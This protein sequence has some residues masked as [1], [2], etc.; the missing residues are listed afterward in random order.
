MIEVNPARKHGDA[1]LARLLLE[2]LPPWLEAEIRANSLSIGEWGGAGPSPELLQTHF[3]Q[4]RTAGV[5]PTH[6]EP[7]A[8]DVIAI[9]DGLPATSAPWPLLRTLGFYAMRHIVVVAPF[10]GDFHTAGSNPALAAGLI[11]TSVD[12]DFQLSS[13]KLIDSRREHSGSPA[14]LRMLLVYSRSR[15]L[16]ASGARFDRE[17]ADGPAI[18]YATWND[19]QLSIL[20]LQMD[21]VLRAIGDG[22][23]AAAY[24]GKMAAAL[25]TAQAKNSELEKR[26][27]QLR[28]TERQLL[29]EKDRLQSQIAALQQQHTAENQSLTARA[30]ANSYEIAT[31]RRLVAELRGSLSWKI[32]APLRALTKPLFLLLGGTSNPPAATHSPA[33]SVVQDDG[34]SQPAPA[35]RPQDLLEP[36]L[37]VLRSARSIA[38]IPC[39]IP[40]SSTLNQR[41]ISCAR[42]LADRGYTVLYVAWQWS[43]GEEI[44]RAGEE[45]Y[46]GVFHLPLYP[47]LNNLDAIASASH[48]QSFYLCTL[49]SPALVEAAGPLRA[50]GYHIHYDIMD[51][52]EGFHRGGEAPWFS[53]PVEREMV[54]LADTVTVVS[55]K[56]AEKFQSLRSDIE[57]VRNGYTPSALSCEVFL[58]ARTPLE[59]PKTI[60][61]FGHLS[62]A[63]FDW[64]ALIHAAKTLPSVDFEII[65]WGVSDA[66]RLH[67]SE[68]ENIR[69]A[70]L[71]PQN[72]LHRYAKRWW[73][74]I[75]PF[76]ST[77]VSAAV[78]PLKIYEYLHLGL[79]S[80]VTGIGG[81]ASFPLVRFAKDAAGFAA[82]IAAIESRPDEATLAE[83]T[84]F[85][86]G[87]VWEARFDS[88]T[89]QMLRPAGL[90]SVYAR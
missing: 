84:E 73:A 46:P 42:Y 90:R 8:F 31:L 47:F 77:D 35:T 54:V 9:P 33:P 79:P 65:G 30:A 18:P 74:G 58:S 36:I 60:G 41:P 68:V 22:K 76:R 21:T 44:P 39:A 7:Q 66:T 1:V 53:R 78:D 63:W 61:Y 3:P 23:D 29:A 86:K 75:I 11:A 62:D 69:L 24:A 14:G 51:E 81:I 71:V 20:S 52:W 56:L 80:I 37:P 83:V 57:V 48:G 25:L 28:E 6:R 82:A 34:S 49:P 45:V 72:E 19:R 43:P 5:D 4:S 40:F 2:N 15:Y 88:L 70:G 87:C 10:A 32:T 59:Q 13:C 89:A 27:E 67:L 85:L 12:P 64:D 26:V 55:D 16:P 17:A 50:A 38:I